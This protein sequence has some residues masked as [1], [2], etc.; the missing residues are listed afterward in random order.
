MSNCSASDTI[1]VSMIYKPIA[2]LGSDTIV[3]LDQ[4][5][6]LSPTTDST[7]SYL[8]N[9]GSTLS[10]L[11]LD[12][13][14]TYWVELSNA[15]ATLRDSIEITYEDCDCH[16]YVPNTFTPNEDY[17]ND[18]FKISYSCDSSYFSVQIFNRWGREIFFS[19][20]V[21]INWDGKENGNECIEDIYVYLIKFKNESSKETIRT[22]RINLVR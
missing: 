18:N 12:Q 20:D 4:S 16:I 11:L 14:G 5:F 10:Y 8:W 7:D 9:N 21:T 19:N 17:L 3:C 13:A 22:G 15:C 2:N 6:M 1:D